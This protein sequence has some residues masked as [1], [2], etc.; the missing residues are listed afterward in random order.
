M[1]RPATSDQRTA[2]HHL[3]H[4]I[5]DVTEWHRQAVDARDGASVEFVGYVR[6]DDHG[7]RIAAL[8]YEAHAPMAER[9]I[10]RVIAEAKR[11]WTLHHVHLRHRLG[12]VA[13]GEAS[14]VISV[15]APHRA[16]AFAACRFL[17]DTIKQDAPIWKRE[18]HA[19]GTTARRHSG[20]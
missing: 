4:D 16:E 9:V 7:R 10:A 2:L 1:Q 17:I 11:R 18:V 14:I 20:C 3:T 6:A 8:D 19:D 12:R 15:H 5:I 13:A